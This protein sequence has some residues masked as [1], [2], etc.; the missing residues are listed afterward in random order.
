MNCPSCG[1]SLEEA[2]QH[3]VVPGAD[4]VDCPNC[5]TRVSPETGRIAEGVSPEGRAEDQGGVP[6]PERAPPAFAGEETLEGVLDEIEEK[7]Q[8]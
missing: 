3:A 5:G 1:Q 6:I 4:V 2:G 7:E 8:S